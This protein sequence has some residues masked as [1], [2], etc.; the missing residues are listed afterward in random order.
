MPPFGTCFQSKVGPGY[1]LQTASQTASTAL[2]GGNL[3]NQVHC[4]LA[5]IAFARADAPPPVAVISFG[6]GL[7]GRNGGNNDM[8]GAAARTLSVGPAARTSLWHVRPTSFEF[9]QSAPG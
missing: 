9:R 3:L 2:S 1:T 8:E 7:Y 6:L 4:G 5:R